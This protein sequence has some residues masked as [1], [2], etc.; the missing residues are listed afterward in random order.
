MNLELLTSKLETVLNTE[1]SKVLFDFS[2]LLNQ[3]FEKEYP[4]VFWDLDNSKWTKELRGTNQTVVMDCFILGMINENYDNKITIWDT[5][6]A[7]MDVYLAEL[8]KL[9]QIQI[10]NTTFI[11]EYYPAGLMT[12]D[13]EVAVRYNLSLKLWC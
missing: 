7:Q 5:L 9:S 12:V 6:E 13:N 4:L 11:K 8:N 10:I 1:I 3:D 2:T